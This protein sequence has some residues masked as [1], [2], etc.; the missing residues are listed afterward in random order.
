[1]SMSEST[2][3]KPEQDAE[4]ALRVSGHVKWFDTAKGYG[5]VVLAPDDYPQI[6]GDVRL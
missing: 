4:P 1:M 2:Q 5:F 3:R 6:S